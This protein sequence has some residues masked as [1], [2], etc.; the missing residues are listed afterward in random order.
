MT[1]KDK[2]TAFIADTLPGTR[3]EDDPLAIAF[4]W[5][6][7]KSGATAYAALK[8][9]EKPNAVFED[10]V[11]LNRYPNAAAEGKTDTSQAAAKVINVIRKGLET[12]VYNVLKFQGGKTT[13][14]LAD[15][16]D[17]PAS[18][19]QPRTSELRLKEFIEDSGLRRKNR[20]GN[21]V[22]VWRVKE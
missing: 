1:L 17:K 13:E 12:E 18:S 22:I 11:Y 8:Q 6:A 19:I 9:Q 2:F 16:L 10:G 15:L 14:E 5:S 7:F 20:A 21:K 4:L 3:L